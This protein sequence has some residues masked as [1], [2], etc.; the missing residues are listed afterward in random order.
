MNHDSYP[1]SYIRGILGQVKTIASTF[2]EA[3]SWRV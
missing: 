3:Y 1:D 2:A